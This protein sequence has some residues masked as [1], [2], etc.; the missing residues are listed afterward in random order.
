M[1][2]NQANLFQMWKI[3]DLQC[4]H[5]LTGGRVPRER[6]LIRGSRFAGIRRSQ[7]LEHVSNK[8]VA[9]LNNHVNLR[10]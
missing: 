4:Q 8:D 9:K 10:V 2:S 7:N 3:Y 5:R 6:V 1:L